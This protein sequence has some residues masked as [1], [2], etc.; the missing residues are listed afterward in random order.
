METF[1][2]NKAFWR[3]LNK[4]HFIAIVSVGLLMMALGFT[5]MRKEVVVA[6]DGN[7]VKVSTFATTVQNLLEEQGIEVGEEDKVVPGINER[8]Q[9]GT[10]IVIHRAFEIQLVDGGEENIILTAENTV[11]DLLNILEIK[12]N[13]DDKVE[14]TLEASLNPG[15]T[16]KITR[17]KREII[18]ENQEI[19]FQTTVK[20]NDAMD[21]GKTERV[22]EGKSGRKEVEIEIL[23]ENGEEI[24][25]EVI[26]ENI[27]EEPVNE[28][29]EKGTAR[30]V[31][32]SRGDNRRYT[33]VIVME[34]SAYTAGYESTGKNPG[35]PYYGVTRSGTRVRPGV[36]AVDP[37]VIP[38]GTK[39]YIESMDRTGDYGVASAEDTGGAIKGN[40]ID[41]YFEDVNEALRFGRRK[42]KV[43]ILE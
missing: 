6:Y 2:S 12:I 11:E 19:A 38:L 31:A 25:R 33:D 7:E 37:K 28:I 43:Y 5:T 29:I 20:H 16:V 10:R 22:Q 34:A 14:P 32:T 13:E 21:Y 27:I 30:M 39:L 42:V 23:Y 40:K 18:T 36:V 17:V 8:L 24:A 35:D 9:K 15:D 1:F 26:V 41:L 3:N 4:K